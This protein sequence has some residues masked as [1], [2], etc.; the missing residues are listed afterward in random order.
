VYVAS[1]EPL[2]QLDQVAVARGGARIL[3]AVSCQIAE[4]AT[5]IVGPS[6][7]GKS[8]LLRLLNRLADP[9]EGTVRFR[10]TD[11]RAHDVLQ[12]RRDVALVSQLPA[13][14]DGT[15]E[16]N[17][18]YAAELARRRVDAPD[19][20]RRSGL[21]ESFSQREATRLSVG[22]QQRVMLARALAQQPTVLLLDEPTSALDPDSR[23]TVERTISDLRRDSGLSL[24]L[25]THDAAQAERLADRSL[26]LEGGRVMA[27][28]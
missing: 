12:L 18:R 5:A 19:I 25:V 6:G 24:I 27:G 8:S 22:E 14:L 26:R 3:T 2:F 28:S 11:V 13:L 21:D 10:G 17:L 23:E 7:A 16:D 1:G 4:A 9:A 15:V 20:L